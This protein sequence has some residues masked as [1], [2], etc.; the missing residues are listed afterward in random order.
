MT[1]RADIEEWFDSGVKEG[2]THMLVVWDSFDTGTDPDYPVFVF[3]D[4]DITKVIAAYDHKN[5]QGV[6][7]VYH[8]GSDRDIQLHAT[9][10]WYIEP[11]PKAP[12]FPRCFVLQRDIDETGISGTGIVAEGV[13]FSDG[14]VALRWKGLWPTSVVFHD[15]G[16]KAVETVHGHGG[17]TRVVWQ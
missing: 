16:M 11:L 13:Q 12:T 17:K 4:Q 3:P 14:V 6:I 5:M 7:E 15:Q 10:A 2:A 8:L 1:T 9:K